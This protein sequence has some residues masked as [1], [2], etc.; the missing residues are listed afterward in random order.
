MQ[1]ENYLPPKVFGSICYVN[2]PF[3]ILIKFVKNENESIILVE[4]KKRGEERNIGETRESIK[5]R[6]TKVVF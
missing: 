3:H 2:L 1:L 6:I 4:E 5:S